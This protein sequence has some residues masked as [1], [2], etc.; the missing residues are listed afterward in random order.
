MA[1]TYPYW[2]SQYGAEWL[3]QALLLHSKFHIVHRSART[4]KRGMG[5]S[6]LL[7]G[8]VRLHNILIEAP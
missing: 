8:E 7:C 2:L 1:T 4:D 5:C 6:A 3:I